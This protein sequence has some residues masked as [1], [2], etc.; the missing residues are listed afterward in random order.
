MLNLKPTRKRKAKIDA[1]SVGRTGVRNRVHVGA[2]RSSR[3]ESGGGRRECA[4]EDCWKG[5]YVHLKP[6][7]DIV[8]FRLGVVHYKARGVQFKQKYTLGDGEAERFAHLECARDG[9][10]QEERLKEDKCYQCGRQFFEEEC[11]VLV[12][13]GGVEDGEFLIDKRGAV[14][15]ACASRHWAPELFDQLKGEE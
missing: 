11:A 1:S 13:V 14:H 7:V 2:R 5:A 8:R 3:K 10:L 4:S 6:G 15:W 9:G 12:Y